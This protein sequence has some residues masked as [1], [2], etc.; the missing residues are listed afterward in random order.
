[1]T[2]MENYK[3]PYLQVEK[4]LEGPSMYRANFKIAFGLVS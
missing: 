1:M 3:L 4:H 2:K